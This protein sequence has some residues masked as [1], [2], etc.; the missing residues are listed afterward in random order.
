MSLAKIKSTACNCGAR[1]IAELQKK[2]R[3]TV[4]SSVSIH[5]GGAHD[6]MLKE[7]DARWNY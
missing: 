7:T 2:A 6:V 5:E 4:V 3:L 1:S